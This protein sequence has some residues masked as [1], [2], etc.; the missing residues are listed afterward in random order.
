VR[1]LEKTLAFYRLHADAKSAAWRPFVVE[2]YRL[3][4]PHWPRFGTRAFRETL[5]S[6]VRAYSRR[7]SGDGPY[8]IAAQVLRTLAFASALTGIGNPEAIGR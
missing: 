7:R 8:G 6:Y 2:L 3:T 1:K 5:A 4:R